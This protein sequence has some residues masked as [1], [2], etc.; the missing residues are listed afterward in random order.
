MAEATMGDT[1]RVHYVGTFDD[2]AVFDDTHKKKGPLEFRLGER[3]AIPGFEVS[4]VGMQ[5]GEK[6]SVRIPAQMGYGERQDDL[7]L[8]VHR[9]EFPENIEPVVGKMLKMP[10]CDER[11]MIVRIS[12]V[13]DTHVTVDGNHPLAGKDLNFDIE[14]LEIVEQAEAAD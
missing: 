1:V 10:Q 4:I 8:K 3:R 9:E 14:L 5:P 12:E 11:D 7:V 6:K 2:G 13:T